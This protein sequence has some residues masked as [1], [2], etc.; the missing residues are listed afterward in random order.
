MKAHQFLLM[1]SSV[2]VVDTALAHHAFT[3]IYDGDGEITI[4]GVV[5][6]FEYINPHAMMKI[7]VTDETG[8]TRNWLAEMA[9]RLSL[10]RYGW[11]ETTVSPGDRVLVT[12]NPTH[13]GA[14]RMFLRRIV[15]A[16]GTE[17]LDPG[18]AKRSQID[19]LR[20]QRARSRA[21]INE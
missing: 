16:D 3:P 15:L 17:L 7:D 4:E 19:E 12:G 5:T 20:R 9:G 1:I 11:S 6:E 21:E 14:E 18:Y 13:S 10:L 8:T 2:G